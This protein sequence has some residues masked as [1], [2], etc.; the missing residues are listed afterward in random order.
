MSNAPET[1]RLG[2]PRK[3]KFNVYLT[4]PELQA[5]DGFAIATGLSISEHVRRAI[6]TYIEREKRKASS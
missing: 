2:L 1:N 3:V 6:D 5:L 4:E